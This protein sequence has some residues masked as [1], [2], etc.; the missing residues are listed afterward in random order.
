VPNP[1]E[2]A[3]IATMRRMK[4]E[5]ATL[6]AI[7]AAVGITAPMTVKR[8]LERAGAAPGE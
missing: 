4:E 3:T 6:R 2:Q 5:G 7:G 1:E 8:I